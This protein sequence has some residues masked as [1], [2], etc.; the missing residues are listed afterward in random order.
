MGQFHFRKILV[1]YMRLIKP[2]FPVLIAFRVMMDLMFD[3]FCNFNDSYLANGMMMRW[4][5][6]QKKS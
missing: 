1:L 4:A 3:V 5:V 2:S 6:Q